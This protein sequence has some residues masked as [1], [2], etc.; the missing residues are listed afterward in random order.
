M[1]QEITV[2]IL[3]LL[4]SLD[5]LVCR[6]VDQTHLLVRFGPIVKSQFEAL[7]TVTHDFLDQIWDIQLLLDVHIV[8][9]L[10]EVLLHHH[11]RKAVL[12][13]SHA[14]VDLMAAFCAV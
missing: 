5:F 1:L 13:T 7:L 12:V 3:S 6:W 4:K 9:K 8:V 11:I 14:V 2:V 10:H